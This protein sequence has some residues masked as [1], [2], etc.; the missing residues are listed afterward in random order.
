MFLKLHI[1]FL[2]NTSNFSLLCPNCVTYV[3]ATSLLLCLIS[4]LYAVNITINLMYA[5]MVKISPYLYLRQLD[6]H[7]LDDLR[8]KM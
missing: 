4:Y 8:D 1:I 3:V 7:Q 5:Y 2:S 6:A